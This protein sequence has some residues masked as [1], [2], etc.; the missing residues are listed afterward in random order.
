MAKRAVIDTNVWLSALYFS[1]KPAQIVNLVEEK[2][3]TSITSQFI[4][5]ELKDKMVNTFDTPTFYASGTVA[6]IQSMSQLV[7]LKGINF[8]LRDSADNKVLE[9]AVVGECNWIITGDKDLLSVKKHN[10]IKIVT[11]NQFLKNR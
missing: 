3:L 7:P 4:L 9:T 11:P 5:N 8:G 2:K 10:Q 6:Y 1:G